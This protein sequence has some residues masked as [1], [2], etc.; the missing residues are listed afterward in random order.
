MDNLFN[1]SLFDGKFDNNPQKGTYTLE[2]LFSLLSKPDIRGDKDGTL[3]CGAIFEGTRSKK[4]AIES[5]LFILDYDHEPEINMTIWD[6]LGV[7]YYFYTTYGCWLGTRLSTVQP[8]FSWVS[9]L[10]SIE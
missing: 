3:I 8:L 9:P 1:I 5:S 7:S 2:Q 4:N 6:S 10:A